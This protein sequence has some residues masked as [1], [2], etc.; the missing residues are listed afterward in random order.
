MGEGTEAR[1]KLDDLAAQRRGSV[2]DL[3]CGARLNQEILRK[4]PLGKQLVF[5]KEIPCIG[6]RAPIA[7]QRVNHRKL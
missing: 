5:P 7:H 1:S 4:R 2:G 6:W 3:G